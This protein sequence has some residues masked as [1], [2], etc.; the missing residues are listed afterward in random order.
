MIAAVHEQRDRAESF[1]AVAEDYDRYRPSYPAQLFDDLVALAPA[2]VLDVGCGTGKAARE[3]AARGLDVLGLEVDPRMATVARA[4]G[5]AV[6]V[7]PFETWPDRGRRYDL[8]TAA[9]SWHWIDPEA[10]AAKA[11]AVLRP[12]GTLALFWN[13]ND[14]GADFD[15]VY[16][17]LAPHLVD[18]G[19]PSAARHADRIAASGLFSVTTREYPWQRSYTADEWVGYART[20]SHHLVLPPAQ[21]DAVTA[22]LRAAIAARGGVV[23]LTGGTYLI[24]ARRDT[25]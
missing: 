23:H 1:G 17:E 16:R 7:A 21:L 12:G 3:L 10:G 20:H 25:G 4:H 19:T 2:A 9:Q 11:A 15:D 5:L 24:L 8:I 14:S 22:G 6:E 13:H 18:D